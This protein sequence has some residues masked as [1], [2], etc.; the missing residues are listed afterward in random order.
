MDQSLGELPLHC[1]GIRLTMPKVFYLFLAS[2]CSAVG[3]AFIA[4]QPLVMEYGAFGMLRLCR[5]LS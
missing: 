4:Y 3:N 1:V 5:G 2:S